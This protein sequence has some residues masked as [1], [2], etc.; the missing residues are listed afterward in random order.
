MKIGKCLPR[1]A[2]DLLDQPDP[3][4]GVDER[5]FLL[6]PA[7]RRQQQ[8]GERGRL[9]RVVHVLH[10]QEVELAERLAELAL[11]DPRVGRV[12]GDDPEA[13]DRRPS[14]MPSMIWSYDQ[15][16]CARDALLGD[17]EQRRRPWRGARGW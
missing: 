7:G 8:V 6:A 2:A 4:L 11:V 14:R 17:A 16:G 13:P 3:P 15:L 10:D 1:C 12:G 5:P 9:G